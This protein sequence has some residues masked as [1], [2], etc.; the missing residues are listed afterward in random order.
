MANPNQKL[1]IIGLVINGKKVEVN[2]ISSLQLGGYVREGET[3]DSGHFFS[4]KPKAFMMEAAVIINS[5]TS[6]EELR[7]LKDA[8]INL[9]FDSGQTYT[10]S[11]GWVKEADSIDKSSGTFTL[12]LEGNA[13]VE[14]R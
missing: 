5:E 1:N 12:S 10:I 4:E 9:S 8:V 6:I 14:V 11:G 3:G 7:N 2:E 13:A